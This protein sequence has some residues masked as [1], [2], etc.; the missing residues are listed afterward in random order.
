MSTLGPSVQAGSRTVGKVGAD[1]GGSR[2]E[3]GWDAVNGIAYDIMLFLHIAFVIALV[4]SA[5]VMH[6]AVSGMARAKTFG[7]Y[8]TFARLAQR[9]GP[10]PS[11]MVLVVLFLGFGLLG[12]NKEK[13][14]FSYSSAWVITAIVM[15]VILEGLSGSILQRHG[16][17]VDAAVAAASAAGATSDTPVSA[18][19]HELSV[20]RRSWVVSITLTWSVIGIVFLMTVKPNALWSI[21]TVVVAALIGFAEGTWIFGRVTAKTAM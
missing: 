1:R 12:M 13:N 4:M 18:E 6:T 3:R 14:D 21:V 19:L 9:F 17:T 8:S 16:K 2:Q 5:A 15:V 10:M 7:T 20:A 11:I